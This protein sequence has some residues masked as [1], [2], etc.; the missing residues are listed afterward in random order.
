MKKKYFAII[1]AL[2]LITISPFLVSL[3]FKKYVTRKDTIEYFYKDIYR[4]SLPQNYSSITFLKIYYPSVLFSML[5]AIVV[6][7]VAVIIGIFFTA[8]FY[9]HHKNLKKIEAF[10]SSLRFLPSLSWLPL[11]VKF[12]AYA[13]LYGLFIFV[14]LG[15]SPI[16]FTQILHGIDNFSSNKRIVF[17]LSQISPI[18]IFLTVI[19]PDCFLNIIQAYRYGLGLGFILVIVYESLFPS[20]FGIT[21]IVDPLITTNVSFID[22]V[23]FIIIISSSGLLLDNMSLLLFDIFEKINIK[24]AIKTY[25]RYYN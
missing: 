23:I 9:Y 18:K 7:I 8:L 25:N 3:K 21:R 14:L 11:L 13:N 2:L 4:Q 19:I 20:L 22:S 16:V 24:R 1:I 6:S 15:I 12:K 17:D 10:F 5:K